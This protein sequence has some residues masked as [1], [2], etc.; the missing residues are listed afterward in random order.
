MEES[1]SDDR[2][3]SKPVRRDTYAVQKHVY[4]AESDSSSVDADMLGSADSDASEDAL[5]AENQ[6][7]SD[8]DVKAEIE[9]VF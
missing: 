6:S 3:A 2:R 4:A 1:R 5:A 8:E 7:S 9:E